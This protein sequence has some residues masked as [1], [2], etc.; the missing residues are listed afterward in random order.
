[1]EENIKEDIEILNKLLDNDVVPRLHRKYRNALI[2]IMNEVNRKTCTYIQQNDDYNTWECSQCKCDWCI[3]EGTPK[4]NNMNYCPECGA[5]IKNIV[6][7]KE[8][9]ND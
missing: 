9:N 1:M 4:D 8:E 3:E 7:Y 2:E 6:E 5:R